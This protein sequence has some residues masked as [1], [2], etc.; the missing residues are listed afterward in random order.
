MF[1]IISKGQTEEPFFY[2][3]TSIYT[4]PKNY[5]F[6][7]Y[8]RAEEPLSE[9]ILP[10]SSG[11]LASQNPLIT[12]S[13]NSSFLPNRVSAPISDTDTNTEPVLM[14]PPTGKILASPQETYS[15][16][17]IMNENRLSRF[18][19]MPQP[20]RNSLFQG[21]AGGLSY[22]PNVSKKNLGMVQANASVTMGIPLPTEE[23]PLLITPSFSW[24][25]LE[26]PQTLAGLP[27]QRE[28]LSLYKSGISFDY[29]FPLSDSFLLDANV[30]VMW[31]S[32][33]RSNSSKAFRINGYG[34]CVWRM[35][36]QALMILGAGYND[37]SGFMKIY[38]IGGILWRPS[39]E[40]YFEA[41]FPRPKIAWRLPDNLA[42]PS[43][44]PYWFYVAAEFTTEKW[45]IESMETSYYS[46][47]KE[48]ELVYYDLRLYVG[49]ERKS[50]SHLNW[51]L[52]GGLV[53]DRNMTYDNRLWNYEEKVSPKAVGFARL[54]MSY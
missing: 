15:S 37:V 42:G 20:V 27:P 43:K 1:C 19:L 31:S 50:L 3:G 9:N 49:L 51:A 13:S 32:D 2:S 14:V 40:L 28:K 45:E 23:S 29:L 53:F 46:Y 10:P 25:D 30:Q 33:F 48:C 8:S 12:D 34:T 16:Q 4:P 39:E 17:S 35:S 18:T 47:S 5:G 7:G 11:E 26:L 41:Y 36:D 52:E 38:P 54:K 22:L 6:F 24:T 44:A 21:A